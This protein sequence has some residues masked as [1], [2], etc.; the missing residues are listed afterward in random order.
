MH[1]ITCGRPALCAVRHEGPNVIANG[2]CWQPSQCAS[3][4]THAGAGMITV[5]A[6]IGVRGFLGCRHGH[7]RQDLH[8]GRRTAHRYSLS[9]P[10]RAALQVAGLHVLWPAPSRMREQYDPQVLEQRPNVVNNPY[11]AVDDGSARTA[12]RCMPFMSRRST[13]A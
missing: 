11:Q 12:I 13:L 1:R 10:R 8:A 6:A 3:T 4:D 7:W 9:G 2:G 5:A